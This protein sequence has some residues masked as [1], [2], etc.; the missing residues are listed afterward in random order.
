MDVVFDSTV[1]LFLFDPEANAPIDPNTSKPL[2]EPAARVKHLAAT[3]HEEH[4]KIIIPTPSLA[5]ILVLAGEATADI[6]N[7]ATH[8]SAFQVAT[9][10]EPRCP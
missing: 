5:E 2:T 8:T 1:L 7:R 10:D 9:F 6:L 4:Q 3:L